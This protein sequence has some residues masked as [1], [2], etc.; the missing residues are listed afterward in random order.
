MDRPDVPSLL[1][2]IHVYFPYSTKPAGDYKLIDMDTDKTV[3]YVQACSFKSA[4]SKLAL[5][6][7]PSITYTAKFMYIGLATNL[8][9]I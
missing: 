2:P 4:I 9:D 6:L 1:P 5:R 3:M 7:S 8:W